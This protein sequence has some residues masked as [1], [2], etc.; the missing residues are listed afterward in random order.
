[1]AKVPH[2]VKITVIKRDIEGAIDSLMLACGEFCI[3]SDHCDCAETA[4]R[5]RIAVEVASHG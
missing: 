2:L 3:T 5:L 1:M 4:E